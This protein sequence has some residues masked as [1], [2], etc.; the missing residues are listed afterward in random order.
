MY[1]LY[2]ILLILFFIIGFPFFLYK[3]LVE[4]KYREGIKERFGFIPSYLKHLKEERPVW[5]HAVSVGEVM[6]TAPL[7][8]RLKGEYPRIKIVLSTVTSTGNRVARSRIRGVDY[9]IYFP[10]DL[11]L[12]VKRV[13]GFINPRLVII[14]ESEIWPNFLRYLKYKGIPVLILNGRI[15]QKSYRRYRLLK[16]FF[17]KVLDNVSCFCMQSYK[18]SERI[19]GI[20]AERDRIVVVGNIKYDQLKEELNP[21]DIKRF[22]ESLGL[23]EK[24][25]IFIAGSTHRGEEG[26]IMEVFNELRKEFGDL[27]LILA[28]RHPERVR[29]VISLVER[30]GYKYIKR[31]EFLEIPPNLE[32]ERDILILDTVGELGKI[33]GVG[34]IIYV[35]GSLVNSGGHNILEPAVYRKPVIFGP[36]MHNFEDIARELKENGGGIEVK[37]REEL[38]EE[39]KKLLKDRD[40]RERLGELAYESIK[41]NRGVI[42]RSMEVVR[43][44]IES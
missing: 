38:V 6:A 28:P 23:N 42:E 37:G 44:Y 30:Y 17:K 15:S 1:Y 9:V 5:I 7:V 2:D 3:R 8:E 12:I 41:K 24:R 14:F 36:Y 34:D 35:G 27:F 18:D 43:D 19:I 33:Y 40:L 26:I 29:E 39:V 10:F 22:R 25:P 11:S 20:G 4:G 31:S 16:R 21:E 32:D 13:I